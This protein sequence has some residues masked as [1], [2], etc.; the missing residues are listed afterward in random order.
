MR[1]F[2]TICD[3][4]DCRRCDVPEGS[5]E[6]LI[7]KAQVCTQLMTAPVAQLYRDEIEKLSFDLI[8]EA[9]VVSEHER[10]ARDDAVV[11]PFR[12]QHKS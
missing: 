12:Q 3:P 2:P 7:R 10:L 5:A 4:A 9:G 6:C 8:E 1:K 11:V